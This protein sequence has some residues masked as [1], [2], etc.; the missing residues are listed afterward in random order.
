MSLASLSVRDRAVYDAISRAATRGEPCPTAREIMTVMGAS[1]PSIAPKCLRRLEQKGLI[2]V[3]R[4]ATGRVVTIRR[5]GKSTKRPACTSPHWRGVK[6]A[7]M[8]PAAGHVLDGPAPAPSF[9]RVR[10]DYGALA[11]DIQKEAFG[12]GHR[13]ADFLSQLVGLGW[14]DY[15]ARKS[16]VRAG[17]GR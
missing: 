4:F 14:R 16:G 13:L 7:A 12:K 10:E 17:H 3:E 11:E 5:T 15:V 6:A 8:V 2:A 9:T 1:T